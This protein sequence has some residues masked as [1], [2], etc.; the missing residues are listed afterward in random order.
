MQ[1][2]SEKK[3]TYSLKIDKDRQ[4]L[5][6]STTEIISKEMWK[7]WP[8]FQVMKNQFLLA[9]YFVTASDNAHL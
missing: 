7:S 3:Q 8:L 5:G 4:D 6:K 2:N 1:E 9:S